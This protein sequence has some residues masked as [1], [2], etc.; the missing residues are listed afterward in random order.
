MQLQP[1]ELAELIDRWW[2]PLTMRLGGDDGWVDDVIQDAFVKLAA[3][4]PPPDHPAA[5]LFRVVGHRR[6]DVG[7]SRARRQRREQRVAIPA[8]AAA[9]AGIGVDIETRELLDVLTP[10]QRTLVVGRVWFDLTFEELAE[11]V[12][13]NLSK[14]YREYRRAIEQLQT[15]CDRD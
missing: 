9:D 1:S 10:D 8:H 2:G 12:N 4:D 14:T 5:W 13:W 3:M 11:E 6:I 15:R 7:R